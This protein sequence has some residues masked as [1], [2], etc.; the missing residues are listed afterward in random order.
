MKKELALRIV[1]LNEIILSQ[2]QDLAVLK[3][4]IKGLEERRD[5]FLWELVELVQ[6]G[7]E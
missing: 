6:G 1:S 4:T 7:D 3:D 5:A 2:K